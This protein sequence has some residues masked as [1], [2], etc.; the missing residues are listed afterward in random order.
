MRSLMLFVVMFFYA[1]SPVFAGEEISSELL[2]AELNNL[3]RAVDSLTAQ[4]QTNQQIEADTGQYRKLDLA[5]AYLNFRSRRIESIE[6]EITTQR[7]I[8]SR[9]EENLPLIDDRIR[10]IETRMQEYPQGAPVEIRESYES[11]V[12][13]REIIQERISRIDE[14]LVMKE[15]LMY[16][17]QSQIRD[18]EDFVQRNLEM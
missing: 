14:Q 4:L 1:A 8:R 16:E 5:I 17:L 9:L 6:R 10:E 3:T 18:V 11:L 13:Q 12:G 15:D 2:A 7:N